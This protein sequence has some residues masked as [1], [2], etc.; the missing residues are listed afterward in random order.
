[1]AIGLSEPLL[2]QVDPMQVGETARSMAIAKAYGQRLQVRSQNFD[3]DALELLIESYPE[4][5][6][7]IDRREAKEIFRRVRAP[8]SDENALVLELGDKAKYPTKIAYSEILTTE[9]TGKAK[10]EARARRK[11]GKGKGVKL[12]PR[13][14]RDTGNSG[15]AKTPGRTSTAS[16]AQDGIR[17]IP[18][19]G[20]G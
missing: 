13:K 3:E 17:L 4:H 11:A 7:V 9:F 14:P 12:V 18:K 2:R 5:G 10:H 8:N 16:A 1:M 20:H 6:F 19:K 15:G